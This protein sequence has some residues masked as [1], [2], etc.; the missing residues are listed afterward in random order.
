MI[1]RVGREAVRNYLDHYLDSIPLGLKIQFVSSLGCLSP[2]RLE[3][4]LIRSVACI[5]SWRRPSS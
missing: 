1:S 5:S 4:I 2:G 3:A